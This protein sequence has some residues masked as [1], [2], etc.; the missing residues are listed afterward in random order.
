M[1]K[2]QSSPVPITTKDNEALR[3]QPANYGRHLAEGVAPSLDMGEG[4]AMDFANLYFVVPTKDQDGQGTKVIHTY[5]FRPTNQTNMKDEVTRA[6]DDF[7]ARKPIQA[8]AMDEGRLG[9]TLQHEANHRAPYLTQE[10]SLADFK[11]AMAVGEQIR[12]SRKAKP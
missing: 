6:W 5:S 8:R 2:H 1:N 7:R 10:P 11:A 3:V 4:Y 9:V 12:D